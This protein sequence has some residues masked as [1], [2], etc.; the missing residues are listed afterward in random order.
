M[1]DT[2]HAYE[3]LELL[4]DSNSRGRLELES[5]DVS[6]EIRSADGRNLRQWTEFW[7]GSADRS[8]DEVSL[9][10]WR[11]CLF[12]RGEG[13]PYIC[14]YPRIEI[15]LEVETDNQIEMAIATWTEVGW[16][17]RDADIDMWKKRS[18]SI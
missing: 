5:Q 17:V 2:V 1:P 18:N 7:G 13:L 12:A 10:Q 3:R 15:E 4:D 8:S 14:M 9:E 6:I 11:V 16:D